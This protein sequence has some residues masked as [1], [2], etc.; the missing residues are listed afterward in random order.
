VRDLAQGPERG[1]G[2]GAGAGIITPL[3]AAWMHARFDRCVPSGAGATSR[4]DRE[5]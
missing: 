4:T 2:R 3:I 5:E 1:A